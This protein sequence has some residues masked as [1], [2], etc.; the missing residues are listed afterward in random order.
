MEGILALIIL[1][2]CSTFLGLTKVLGS[3]GGILD[4]GFRFRCLAWGLGHRPSFQ[5][6][7][8]TDASRS[9]VYKRRRGDFSFELGIGH[10]G[11]DTGS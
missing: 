3:L 8:T 11:F 10:L 7:E 5:D 9:R 2:P 6:R 4:F 1:T